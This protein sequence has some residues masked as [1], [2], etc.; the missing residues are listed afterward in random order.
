M[1]VEAR[2]RDLLHNHG[3]DFRT[4]FPPK[5]RFRPF[6]ALSPVRNQ[7]G[8]LLTPKHIGRF[9]PWP[10]HAQLDDPDWCAGLIER[11]EGGLRF[12]SLALGG[13]HGRSS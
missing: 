10:T 12:T 4:P 2:L 11:I 1:T 7:Y 9:F 8:V 6:R 13:P 3:L 5:R